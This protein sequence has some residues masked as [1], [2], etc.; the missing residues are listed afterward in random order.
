MDGHTEKNLPPDPP[1][2]LAKLTDAALFILLRTPVPVELVVANALCPP[3]NI[4]LLAT[5]IDTA[6]EALNTPISKVAG[7]DTDSDVKLLIGLLD[8]PEQP[9]E[10]AR[11]PGYRLLRVLGVGGMGIVFQAEDLKLNRQVAIKLIRPKRFKDKNATQRFLTEARAAARLTHDNIVTVYHV[12]QHGDIPYLVMQ[13]LSGQS[14]ADRMREERKLDV[15]ATLQ[16]TRQ[17]ALGLAAA[18]AE[19]MLHR[20][21]KPD[22]IWLEATS[23]RVKILDFGLA[24]LALP[25]AKSPDEII[26]AGT[27][28]YIA[29]ERIRGQPGDPR[30]D[31]FSLGVVLY[32]MLSGHKPFQASGVT[33]TLQLGA[34]HDPEPLP[35][36]PAPFDSQTRLL[37]GKLLEKEPQRR[38]TDAMELIVQIDRILALGFSDPKP[39]AQRRL[40]RK[41]TLGLCLAAFI[42]IAV[43]LFARGWNVSG[44]VLLEAMPDSIS[45]LDDLD[46]T[47]RDLKTGENRT[48][49][50]GESKLKPGSYR[51]EPSAIEGVKFSRDQFELSEGETVSLDVKY[52]PDL[53]TG[54]LAAE[55]SRLI[56][57]TWLWSGLSAWTLETRLHRGRIL[58]L[59]SNFNG[60]W[61]ATGG[62]DAI[63]HIWLTSD[64]SLASLLIG[65]DYSVTHVEWSPN[66][67][68]LIA[69]TYRNITLWDTDRS[70][71]IGTWPADNVQ[72]VHWAPDGRRFLTVDRQSNLSIYS[73]DSP[74]VMQSQHGR[75]IDAQW[76][77]D[78]KSIVGLTVDGHFEERLVESWESAS[79]AKLRIDPSGRKV[80]ARGGQMC[81]S[82]K[83]NVLS[84]AEIESG[85]ILPSPTFNGRE[86]QDVWSSDDGEQ[87]FAQ[88]RGGEY[89]LLHSWDPRTGA[90]GQ[91]WGFQ[92]RGLGFS[93]LTWNSVLKKGFFF[94][95]NL[96]PGL[97]LLRIS[98]DSAQ[99]VPFRVSYGVEAGTP[100]VV[101]RID[102]FAYSHDGNRLAIAHGSLDVWDAET[103]KFIRECSGFRHAARFIDWTADDSY[104][105]VDTT[106]NDADDQNI[107]LVDPNRNVEQLLYAD[108]EASDEDR[109]A[110]R[111]LSGNGAWFLG[112][113]GVETTLISTVTPTERRHITVPLAEQES[114]VARAISNQGSI[115]IAVDKK[116]QRTFCVR[117]V[118]SSTQANTLD[119][120]LPEPIDELF[121]SPDGMSLVALGQSGRARAFSAI[122]GAVQDLIPLRQPIRGI[123]WSPDSSR[124]AVI[125]QSNIGIVWDLKTN[126]KICSFAAAAVGRP[127]VK[128]HPSGE[129]IGYLNTWGE[130]V[131]IAAD[132]GRV[133]SV[134]FALSGSQ[135]YWIRGDESIESNDGKSHFDDD[136]VIAV[137][138]PDGAQATIARVTYFPENGHYYEFVPASRIDWKSARDLAEKKVLL[139]AQGGDRHGYLATITSSQEQ[140]F[141]EQKFGLLRMVWIG[142]TDSEEDGQWRWVTGPEGLEENGK[143]RLIWTGLSAA[144]G[145]FAPTVEVGQQSDSAQEN[146]DKSPAIPYTAPIELFYSNWIPP[147]GDFLGEPNNLFDEDFLIWN[148]DG[149]AEGVRGRFGLWNDQMN[150]SPRKG[151]IV[152]G[153]L[154]EYGD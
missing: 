5:E 113:N 38:S 34:H 60:Q 49:R 53:S 92:D 37:V 141:L 74:G 77:E 103:G 112:A 88:I 114:I 14:L 69:A 11:L 61:L 65:H 119:I 139:D 130:V 144:N 70:T 85:Q 149:S 54:Y 46:F 117:I 106:A 120:Q 135:M 133:A 145:G 128:W 90:V 121:W 143:G 9:D 72:K 116:V 25:D 84:V 96:V 7:A 17:I 1:E 16:I 82:L 86:I 10:L 15:L 41:W 3:P 99:P 146:D 75:Y 66:D 104:I 43:F 151:D 154:V 56:D 6:S 2:S 79:P 76:R 73:V 50:L 19:G 101:R 122:D 111:V 39:D 138:M 28:N 23:D 36:L 20:D 152:A 26:L 57:P 18:H 40:N 110:S 131:F 105:A 33:G 148:H 94:V 137:W 93:L 123:S 132:A 30:S 44:A 21:I 13:L 98:Q 153:Y 124:L 87:C 29:P 24:Q 22:N 4:P 100:N 81:V 89:S 68:R 47:V 127:A 95:P 108:T 83:N 129:L 126:R 52:E 55:T 91:V 78:S 62:D 51:I 102:D 8:P 58:S 32:E 109:F 125:S 134:I 147:D 31:L 12:G 42:A 115:A 97:D 140:T 136:I 150:S 118:D 63:V 142:G 67:N 64:M 35:P 59:D 71:K 48:M 107:Y 80:L 27:P 45:S